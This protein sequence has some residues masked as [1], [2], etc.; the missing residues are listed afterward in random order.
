MKVV[1]AERHRLHAPRHDIDAGVPVDNVEVPA[2][3]ERILASLRAVP[4]QFELVAPVAHGVAPIEAVHSREMIRFLEDMHADELFPD[5]TLNARLREGMT[6]DAAEPEVTIGRIGYWCFDTGTP[7]MEHTYTAAREAVDVAL[8][9][10]DLLLGGERVTYGLCRPPGHHAAHSV[11]GGFCYFNNAAIA[12]SHLAQQTG[13]KIAVLDLD[14]HHGNGTQQIFYRRGDVLYVSIHADPRRAFPY[15]T[16][17]ADET[18]A[19]PGL[20]ANCNIPLEPNV[21]DDQ[22]LAALDRGL[23]AL[24]GFGSAITIVSLGVDT[25]QHD[26]LG[27]F[28]LT[29]SAYHDCARQVASAA[30]R[31][32]VLQEGGYYLQDLGDNVRQFLLGLG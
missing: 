12:A 30:K 27:D 13:E 19:G 3:A 28:A 6:S 15:Y 7:V 22:Y 25:Y 11:F 2:R 23:E 18:G 8:T 24:S 29:T 1:Y 5:T 21:D 4:S 31:I 10:A 9:A 20:G 32:L 17:H 14:Y 26:P 16:G